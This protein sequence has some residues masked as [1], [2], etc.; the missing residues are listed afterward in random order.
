MVVIL[1]NSRDADPGYIAH[2]LPKIARIARNVFQPLLVH[3]NA[4][5]EMFIGSIH[6]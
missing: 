2:L 1:T 3:E 6:A 4:I 5:V